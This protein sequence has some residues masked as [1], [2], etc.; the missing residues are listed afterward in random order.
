MIVIMIFGLTIHIKALLVVTE[1]LLHFNIL[2]EL[3]FMFTLY[4]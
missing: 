4:S 1:L 2:P 3:Q